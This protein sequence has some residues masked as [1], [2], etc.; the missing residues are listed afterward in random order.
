[1]PGGGRAPISRSLPDPS[2]PCSFKSAPASSPGGPYRSRLEWWQGWGRELY[3]SFLQFLLPSRCAVCQDT[4]GVGSRSVV[5]GGCW[6]RIRFLCP[7][8]C[9]RCGRPFWGHA[10]AHPPSHLCQGC[11]VRRPRYLLARSALLYERDDPLREILLVFKHGRRESLGGHLGR[12]M[13]DRAPILFGQPSIDAVVPVPLHKERERERGFNQAE[14]LA[15][16]VANRFHRPVLRKALARIRRT[17]PQAGKPR[18][19]MRNVRGAFAVGNPETVK[20]RTLLLVDDV[21]TTG[22]TVNECAKVL[23]KAGAQGVFVYTLARVL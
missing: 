7:P 6:S 5:C 18:E 13:A 22:A 3:F 17:P 9:P 1:M 2:P 21:F 8:F 19:R 23:M 4:L 11:R 12:L 15:G 10:V 16:V 14:L 20:D